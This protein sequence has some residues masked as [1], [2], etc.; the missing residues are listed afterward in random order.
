VKDFAYTRTL[1][2]IFWVRVS[3]VPSSSF[4]LGCVES[5]QMQLARIMNDTWVAIQIS[6]QLYVLSYCYFIFMDHYYESH[7][8]HVHISIPIEVR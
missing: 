8:Q 7:M 3:F 4:V 1:S 5:L 2:I 6:N